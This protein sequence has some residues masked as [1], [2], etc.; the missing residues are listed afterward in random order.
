MVRRHDPEELLAAAVEAALEAGLSELTFGRLAK[1]IGIPDR[2][3]VYYFPTKQSLL[4][5]VLGVL[6][7][8]LFEQLDEA[9][10]SEP[11]PARDLLERAYPVLSG[12]SAEPVFALWFELAGHGAVGQEPHRSLGH[13]M[14]D[15]WLDWVTP[16]V[17]APTP[18]AA[19]ADAAWLIATLDGALLLHHLGHPQI[20]RSA[21]D[22]ATG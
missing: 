22:R 19:R 9:F 1:R 6:A 18:T 7:G 3:L 10:G 21:I 2:T 17:A 12:P 13:A 15:A 8:Q 16:R 20:A 14:L 4:E 5:S 11:R